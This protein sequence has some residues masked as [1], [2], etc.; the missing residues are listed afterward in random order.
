MCSFAVTIITLFDRAGNFWLQLYYFLPLLQR[1]QSGA[2]YGRSN[3]TKLKAFKLVEHN[4]PLLLLPNFI[5]TGDI[6][7]FILQ[8]IVTMPVYGQEN[9]QYLSAAHDRYPAIYVADHIWKCTVDLFFT[10][11]SGGHFE[12]RGSFSSVLRKFD[13][14]QRNIPD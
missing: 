4:T 11:C 13:H 8:Q 6:N 10:A 5:A 1:K 12:K 9:P 14:P 2:S 7:V 3:L